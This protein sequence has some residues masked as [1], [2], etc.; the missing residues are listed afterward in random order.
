M[1]IR[2]ACH[3]GNVRFEL[4]WPGDALQEIP[5]RACG[6]TFCRKHGATWTS[7]PQARLQSTI[8]NAAAVNGY[9]FGTRT[10]TFH[11]CTR[12]GVA[13]FVSCVL[14]GVRYAV[15]NVNC[16]EGDLRVASAP[17]SFEGEDLESRLARRKRNWI[18]NVRIGS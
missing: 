5:A 6:C 17:A 2:G 4:E 12:C 18:A 1:R 14:D 16:F 11:V 8:A 15:V 7:H 13:P 9:E 10:A 3:C